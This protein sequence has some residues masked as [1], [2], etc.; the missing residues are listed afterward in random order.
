[1]R[2][3]DRETRRNGHAQFEVADTIAIG[4]RNAA[5]KCGGTTASIPACLLRCTWAAHDVD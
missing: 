1:M 2:F 3:V 5:R 4:P